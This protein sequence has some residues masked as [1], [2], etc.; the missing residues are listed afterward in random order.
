MF[1]RTRITVVFA[2]A[3]FLAGCAYAGY[4]N[5]LLK[6][7][8]APVHRFLV[9]SG[10]IIGTGTLSRWIIGAETKRL[11]KKIRRLRSRQT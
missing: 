3:A 7:V 10:F 4:V 2:S 1:S 8:I 9:I 6:G 11:L 5:E